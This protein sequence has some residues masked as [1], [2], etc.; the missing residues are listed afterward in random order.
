MRN[1]Q[2]TLGLRCSLYYS[3]IWALEAREADPY[4]YNDGQLAQSDYCVMGSTAL[5]RF[6]R[7]SA[8]ALA[9]ESGASPSADSSVL[10]R[11]FWLRRP[12]AG[13]RS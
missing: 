10:G 7:Y 12:R 8:Q 11:K 2:P 1:F 13:S 3:Q 9:L 5:S 6:S 4:I